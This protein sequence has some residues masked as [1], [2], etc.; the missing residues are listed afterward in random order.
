[1]CHILFVLPLA[2][3]VLFAFLPFSEAV[4]LYLPIVIVCGFFY[5]VVW[6]DMHLPVTLGVE[7]LIGGV[8]EVLENSAGRVK[9]YYKSEI[10]DAVC[11]EPVS[12]GEKVEITGLERMTLIV[13]LHRPV[14]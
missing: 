6:R 13:K 12:R 2:A 3:V 4:A 9:V 11:A 1:M 10:W 14:R 5:W 8:A 7:G